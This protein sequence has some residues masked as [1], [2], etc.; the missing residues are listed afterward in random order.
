MINYSPT[1]PLCIMPTHAGDA[2]GHDALLRGLMPSGSR[3]TSLYHEQQLGAEL[4]R[5]FPS[6]PEHLR[7]SPS[8]PEPRSTPD[9]TGRGAAHHH[10]GLRPPPAA[11]RHQHGQRRGSG[12][13]KLARWLARWLARRLSRWRPSAAAQLRLLEGRAL[14]SCTQARRARRGVSY[15]GERR[16]GRGVSHRSLQA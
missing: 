3:Y 8:T 9:R 1:L 4:L 10:R 2:R 15:R 13:A 14:R 16:A 11:R 7:E 5:V 6:T 12:W